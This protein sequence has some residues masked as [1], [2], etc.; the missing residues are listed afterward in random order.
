MILHNIII[1]RKRS[2]RKTDKTMNG[3]QTFTREEVTNILSAFAGNFHTRDFPRDNPEAAR[4]MI[5]DECWLDDLSI[6]AK[7]LYENK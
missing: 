3:K 1:I 6:I 4:K 7:Q 5:I 2:K